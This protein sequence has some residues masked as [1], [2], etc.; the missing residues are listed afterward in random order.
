MGLEKPSVHKYSYFQS[1][2]CVNVQILKPCGGRDPIEVVS[3]K[4]IFGVLQSQRTAAFEERDW[5]NRLVRA[6]CYL[7]V[8]DIETLSN[9][10]S[11]AS[12]E[13]MTHSVAGD[14]L[15]VSW[16][17]LESIGVKHSTTEGDKRKLHS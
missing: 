10:R 3:I 7:Q 17:R 5:V 9:R 1:M 14:S 4:I 13:V 16:V 2:C 8:L 6:A 15:T 12:T 11:A